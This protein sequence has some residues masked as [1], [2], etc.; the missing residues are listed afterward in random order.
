MQIEEF[1]GKLLPSSPWIAAVVFVLWVY[2][3]HEF[4]LTFGPS[5]KSHRKK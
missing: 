1:I 5:D 2:R 4:H 3:G